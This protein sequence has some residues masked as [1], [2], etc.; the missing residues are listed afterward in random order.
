MAAGCENTPCDVCSTHQRQ[1][2]HTHA[3]AH[4]HMKLYKNT[5]HTHARR[6]REDV[7]GA[8][9]NWV[10]I[11]IFLVIAVYRPSKRN[12]TKRR[13]DGRERASESPTHA[14]NSSPGG[15]NH[16]T[17]A[18]ENNQIGAPATNKIVST[19]VSTTSYVCART[20]VK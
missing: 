16:C 10:T 6:C 1:H 17:E 20:R 4:K 5:R 9:K 18:K 3:N 19:Y 7:T 11:I 15:S 2:R 12:E 14:H 8:I 13:E